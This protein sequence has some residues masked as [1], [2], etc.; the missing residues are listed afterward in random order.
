MID[1]LARVVLWVAIVVFVAVGALGVMTSWFES[2]WLYPVEVAGDLVTLRNQQR[3]LK[4][5]ELAWGVALFTL[6]RD[7]F[8]DPR[9]TRLVLFLFWVTPLSRV[10]SMALE[11]LPHRDFVLLVC[12]ELVGAFVL[13]ARAVYA[14][15][16]EEA[17]GLEPS[18]VG[19]AAGA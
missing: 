17:G 7:V 15:G 8:V 4:S 12:V 3:F 5:L 2:T 16:A 18:R 11:G 1:R 14:P 13:S 19:R 9:I 6:R 10:L